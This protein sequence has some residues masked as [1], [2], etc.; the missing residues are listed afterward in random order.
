MKL[1]LSAVGVFAVIGCG[2]SGGGGSTGGVSNDKK[3]SELTDSEVASLCEWMG[4][5]APTSS[6]EKDC[7]SAAVLSSTDTASCESFREDC[8][9]DPATYLG[10]DDADTGMDCSTASASD[11]G[12]GCKATVGELRS[13]IEDFANSDTDWEA[14]LNCADVPTTFDLTLPA[15][16]SNVEVCLPF[17]FSDQ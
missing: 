8:L 14:S 3:A 11:S 13:C 10:A 17:L 16:C 4:E 2:D 9:A 12:A 6:T 7:N 15:S 1:C 5:V